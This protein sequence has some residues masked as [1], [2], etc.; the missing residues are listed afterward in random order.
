[1]ADCHF[2][3]VAAGSTFISKHPLFI[4][5]SH[6]TIVLLYPT[7]PATP[8]ELAVSKNLDSAMDLDDNHLLFGDSFD[9]LPAKAPVK[10]AHLINLGYY[11][12]HGSTISCLKIQDTVATMLFNI[13]L[14]TLELFL[15]SSSN[16]SSSF[17]VSSLLLSSI[18]PSSGGK[19][20]RSL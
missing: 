19:A 16:R 7:K 11:E 18:R 4:D 5:S 13:S 15:Y 17:S 14:Q 8:I 10:Y 12:K 6:S 1:L 9:R 20:A 2:C 3:R